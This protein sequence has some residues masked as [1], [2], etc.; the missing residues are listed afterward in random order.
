LGINNRLKTWQSLYS[1]YIMS[2]INFIQEFKYVL[3]S[4]A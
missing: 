2:M 1:K 4:N 3:Q